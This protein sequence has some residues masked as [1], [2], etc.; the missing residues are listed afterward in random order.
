MQKE[1]CEMAKRSI[2]LNN[3]GQRFEIINTNVKNL[4]DILGRGQFDVVVSNPPY[5][6]NDT[7]MINDNYKKWISRHEVEGKLEDF[8]RAASELLREKG[9]F[10][11]VHRPERL[12]DIL[13]CLRNYKLEPK[14]LRIVQPKKDK[15]PNLILIK[16]VKY[17]KPFMQIDKPLVIYEENGDYTKEV[18]KIYGGIAK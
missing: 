6:K 9:A 7:G 12:V 5:K 17:A 10:Y 2:E 15:F 1:V 8:I 11:L 18:M 14:K 3:L 4:Y 13:S 16:S